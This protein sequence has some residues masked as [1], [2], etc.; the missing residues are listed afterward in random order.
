[1]KKGETTFLKKGKNTKVY[2]GIIRHLKEN[3]EEKKEKKKK[4]FFF[5]F[6]FFQDF[7]F[8]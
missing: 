2:V 6:Q 4:D 5:F 7:R 3:Q 1:L 8:F